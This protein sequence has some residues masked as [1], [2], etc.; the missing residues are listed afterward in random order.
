MLIH[1]HVLLMSSL[2]A[3]GFAIFVG[4]MCVRMIVVGATMPNWTSQNLQVV[5][6]MAYR[7]Q[8]P[9]SPQGLTSSKSELYR[10]LVLIQIPRFP[11][12]SEYE[13]T[14]DI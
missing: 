8:I 7:L 13:S 2:F 9:A 5:W 11:D 14:M 1:R 10:S 12:G 3:A 4:N 6:A